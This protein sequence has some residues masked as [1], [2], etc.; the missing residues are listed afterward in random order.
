VKLSARTLS[1]LKNFS[2]INPSIVFPKG[3]PLV[4]NIVS[5]ISESNGVV[6]YVEVEEEFPV[7][8]ALYDLVQFLN[9]YSTFTSPEIEFE[10]DQLILSEGCTRLKY[11]YTPIS[12][13]K[14]YPQ[15][16][17]ISLPIKTS[18]DAEIIKFPKDLLK[19]CI[20]VSSVLELPNISFRTDDKNDLWLIIK[21]SSINSSSGEFEVVLQNTNRAIDVSFEVSNFKL[22]EGDYNLE[23]TK[24]AHFTNVEFP[25][26]YWIGSIQD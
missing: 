17:G 21:D 24:I 26:Q 23:L 3:D 1:V 8:F 5:T 2:A 25:L 9:V 13:I 14:S 19:T 11:R 6:G 10:T 4:G 15:K 18:P 22:F 16:A 7:T 20:K 12:L